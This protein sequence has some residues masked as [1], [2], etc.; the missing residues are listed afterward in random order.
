MTNG[1]MNEWIG[2]TDGWIDKLGY[3]VIGFFH[4]SGD[5]YPFLFST[6]PSDH[7]GFDQ[8]T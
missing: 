3:S 4:T 8:F 2:W 1:R 5:M 7:L 6:L